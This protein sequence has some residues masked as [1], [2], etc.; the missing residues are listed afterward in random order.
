MLEKLQ[1]VSLQPVLDALAGTQGKIAGLD[2]EQIKTPVNTFMESAKERRRA[3]GRAVMRSQALGRSGGRAGARVLGPPR[4]QDGV[5]H[6]R[7]VS[8]ARPPSPADWRGRRGT[9]R[10]A[11]N[12][13]L[14][15]SEMGSASGITASLPHVPSPPQAVPLEDVGWPASCFAGHRSDHPGRRSR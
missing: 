7:D 11:T 14:Q 2:V 15:K 10:H 12:F 5:G 6:S 8:V 13:R 9:D 1:G 3:G 4:G